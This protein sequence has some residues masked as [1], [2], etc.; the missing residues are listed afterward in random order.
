M[1][2][3]YIQPFIGHKRLVLVNDKAVDVE[4]KLILESSRGPLGLVD[5]NN[6]V[7]IFSNIISIT[8][9]QSIQ[10]AN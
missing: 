5:V 2:D 8:P 10:G 4:I 1:T 9:Q 6:V 7:Y 3:V